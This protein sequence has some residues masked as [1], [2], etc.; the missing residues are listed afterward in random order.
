MPSVEMCLYFFITLA[1]KDVA[2]HHH[3]T[4]QNIFSPPYQILYTAFQDCFCSPISS[5]VEPTVFSGN[6]T[7]RVKWSKIVQGAPFVHR[8]FIH[9]FVATFSNQQNFF[10]RVIMHY[11]HLIEFEK[12]NS[13]SLA[14]FQL[15]TN[16]ATPSV[17]TP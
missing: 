10:T 16:L 13:E 2:N 9:I 6:P 1:A 7:S 15:S 12:T 3:S 5:R 14:F 11:S 4:L 17:S 8:V